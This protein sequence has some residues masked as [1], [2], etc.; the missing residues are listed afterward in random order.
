MLGST[1]NRL[2]MS[3]SSLGLSLTKPTVS[4]RLW[5]QETASKATPIADDWRGW[6]RALFP[7]YVAHPF[8]D[9]HVDAWEWAW[10]IEKEQRPPP[11]VAVWDRGGGKSTTAELI[12]VALG[13]RRRR[14][15]CLYTC[16]TQE[17]ADDHVGNIAALME[18]VAFGAAYPEMADRMLGK[19]GNSK[20]WRRNRLRTAGGFTVDALGLDTAARGVKLEAQR[21][22]L[23]II[24]DIDSEDDSIETTQ[25]KIARLSRKVLPVGLPHTVHLAIQNLVHPDSVFAQLVDGRADMLRDRILSGPHPA[26][27]G[28]VYDEARGA[29]LD[30]APTWEGRDLAACQQFVTTWGLDAFRAECQHEPIATT[31]RF[32]LSMGLWD[33]CQIEMPPLGA[34]ERVVLALDAGESSDTFATV[35][36]S[37][38]PTVKGGCAARYARAYVPDG[39][40]LNFDA[41]ERDVL[42]LITRHAVVAVVYD[43]F[44]LGQFMRRLQTRGVPLPPLVP[45]AQGAPR[46]EADKGLLD[47]IE[48]RRLGHNGDAELRQH[49]DNA[50]RKVDTLSRKLRIVKRRQSLKIDLAVALSMGCAYA[51]EALGL[52]LGA[53]LLSMVEMTS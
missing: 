40:V 31:G 2:G 5:P 36:V 10:A 25:K 22:D 19:F 16:M 3:L 32:L 17:Q 12:A 15:Y 27:L 18:S 51:V 29:L 34:H 20:G 8:A 45:F 26:L 50:N 30:G 13:A 33:A 23:I 37:E 21:P 6:L 24:D 42:D 28:A 43:P 4:W 35:L 9:R 44:L 7:S 53:D 38:H 47:L 41:I 48:Q 11:F 49:I 14:R 1:N 52:P 39:E 46:L